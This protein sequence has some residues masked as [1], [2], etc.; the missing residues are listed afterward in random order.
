MYKKIKN[1]FL[2]W[3]LIAITGL[4]GLLVAY[5]LFVYLITPRYTFREGRPFHG[6]CLY[7]PYQGMDSSQW[8]QYNFHCHSRKYF[9]ITNGRRSKEQI[10]DS[11]YQLLGYDHYGISDYMSINP[12]GND[13]PGYIPGYE[14][15]YGFIRKTHQLCIGA[16]DIS[17]MDYPF[18]QSLDMKQHMLNVL[19]QHNRFAVPAHAAYTRGYKV[20]D[21]RYLSGYRLLEVLNPYG[22]SV[23]HWDAALSTGHRVYAIGDDDTHNILNHNEVG[24]NFTMINTIDMKPEN[25]YD[26]LE[27]GCA[28]A[29]DFHSYFDKP[30]ALKVERMHELPHL[31]RCELV[32]D[33]LFVET[34]ASLIE[35]ADF[36]GQDGKVLKHEEYVQQAH[37]V[38][39]PNDTYV[40]VLL[41]MP[42]LTY[43]YLN[44][45]TRHTD[46]TPVDQVTAEINM[47]QTVMFYIIYLVV[48]V[49]C[50][51]R[52]LKKR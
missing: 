32:G 51:L 11:V 41:R 12:H 52:V 21:M 18:M 29:V 27:R 48:I 37:Y 14:H 40:R 30:F 23:E 9:G 5:W 43:F 38:I 17:Y 15:G 36:I 34:S 20:S 28:Y 44:P 31:T 46:P 39:Q 24:R 2:R 49:L 26:A 16:Q 4:F 45:I 1:K 47:V 22:C 6:E 8:K 35:M 25:V 19:H 10:I 3:F 50:I 13:R 33:T 42:N 7:N